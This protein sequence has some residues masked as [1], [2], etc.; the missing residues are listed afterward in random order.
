MHYVTSILD[1]QPSDLANIFT[2]Y[3]SVVP[4]E[5]DIDKRMPRIYK[6]TKANINSIQQCNN[7]YYII[8]QMISPIQDQHDLY[9]IEPIKRTVMRIS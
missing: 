2:F 9:R 4:G 3:P 1:P 6:I 5:E 7:L 8:P